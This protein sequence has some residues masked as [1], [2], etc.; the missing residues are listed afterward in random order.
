MVFFA[1]AGSYPFSP[2]GLVL[3]QV[4][5]ATLLSTGDTIAQQFA[6]N[7]GMNHDLARTA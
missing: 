1:M 6:E 7:K 4:I 3:L 2:L 5:A